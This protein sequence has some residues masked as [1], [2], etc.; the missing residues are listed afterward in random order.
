MMN[1][2]TQKFLRL[3]VHGI[4]GV[5]M[6]VGVLCG[7]VIVQQGAVKLLNVRGDDLALP[8]DEVGELAIIRSRQLVINGESALRIALGGV[9]ILGSAYA[10]RRIERRF[11][12]APDQAHSGQ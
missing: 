3:L 11:S 8:G 7:L 5:L 10:A 2:R 4:S 1:M 6:A 12:P 9:V